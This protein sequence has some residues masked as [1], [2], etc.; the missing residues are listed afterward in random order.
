[1]V[2]MPFGSTACAHD[3]IHPWRTVQERS[4]ARKDGRWQQHYVQ[5]TLEGPLT[6]QQ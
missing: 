3:L 4:W 2:V 5:P 6:S 1:V